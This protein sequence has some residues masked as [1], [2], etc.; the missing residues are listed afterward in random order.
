VSPKREELRENLVAMI[1]AG[2]E[3]PPDEDEHLVDVF[4][5]Y[6]DAELELARSLASGVLPGVGAADL[7]VLT[8]AE[9][10]WVLWGVGASALYAQGLFLYQLGQAPLHWPAG[11]ASAGD[12]A[13]VVLLLWIVAGV[14]LPWVYRLIAAMVQGLRGS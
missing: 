13:I 14:F 1:E 6:L 11:L 12:A 9:R 3:L 7:P 8:R 4:V 2:R 10:R 5:D